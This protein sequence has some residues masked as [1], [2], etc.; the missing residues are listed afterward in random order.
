MLKAEP[1]KIIKFDSDY[2]I[3]N[4]SSWHLIHAADTQQFSNIY[5]A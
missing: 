5:V 4:N 1:N 3:P 2:E